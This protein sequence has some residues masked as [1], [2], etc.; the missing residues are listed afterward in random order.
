MN[1]T[2]EDQ[3]ACRK[4]LHIEVPEELVVAEYQDVARMYASRAKVPG[5]RP[6]KVPVPII[7][8]KFRKEIEQDTRERLVPK[9][10]RDAISSQDLEP[11]AVVSVSDSAVQKGSPLHIDVTVDVKPT[12]DL[13]KYKGMQVHRNKIEVSDEEV[14]RAIDSVREQLAVYEDVAERPVGDEDLVEVSYS[15]QCDDVPVSEI[16][17]DP[18]S[19]GAAEKIWMPIGGTEI[20]PGVGAALVGA[21][22]GEERTVDVTF[23]DDYQFPELAGKS[24][25][26]TVTVGT[27]R[28]KTLPEDSKLVQETGVASI[29]ELRD[30]YREQLQTMQDRTEDQRLKNEL[31]RMLTEQVN[32][33]VPESVVD[34]EQRQI[35]H[36]IVSSN[37]QR[38]ISRDDL[39]THKEEISQSAESQSVARVKGNFVLG[40]ISEEEGI[41]V[42]DN[43]LEQHVATMAA[44][45]G[46]PPEQLRARLEE[47]DRLDSL[48]DDLR[49]EKTMQF[50]LDH[51]EI[52]EA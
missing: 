29:E 39:A 12:I 40:R 31:V 16:L 14:D 51:A 11:L 46:M 30:R 43:D 17:A 37:I 48:K 10:Y 26:Y 5:Y 36:D 19:L 38:G 45:Y 24:A 22:S 34:A 33:E 6:G 1:V 47:N 4:V 7:E 52:K 44:Q 15:G 42:S 49:M 13:P 21:A 50:L 41:E 8:R 9:C 25:V 20:I 3:G 2:V 18:P 27:I 28:G 32:P 35:I 23:P